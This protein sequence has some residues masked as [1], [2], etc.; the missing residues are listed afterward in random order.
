MRL[1]D[2]A[3]PGWIDHCSIPLGARA[4]RRY[5]A[6]WLSNLDRCSTLYDGLEITSIR[7]ICSQAGRGRRERSPRFQG[8]PRL[9]SQSETFACQPIQGSGRL[10]GSDSA[11]PRSPI[12]GIA[13]GPWPADGITRQP[14]NCS[15]RVNGRG[16]RIAGFVFPRTAR[17][18]ASIWVSSVRTRDMIGVGGRVRTLVGGAGGAAGASRP[19]ACCCS[20]RS[21]HQHQSGQGLRRNRRHSMPP[22]HGMAPSWL[23]RP[24]R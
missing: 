2:T 14:T 3:R 6:P 9:R 12:A 4:G 20:C 8:C 15:H 10:R 23:A 17:W 18:S 16:A 1:N 13:R 22:G 5:L 21:C 11:L 19:D 7:Y 24:G